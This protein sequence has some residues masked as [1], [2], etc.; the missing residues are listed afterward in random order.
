MQV[1]KSLADRLWNGHRAHAR[2]ADKDMYKMANGGCRRD[3]NAK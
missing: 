3:P 1:R 2:P